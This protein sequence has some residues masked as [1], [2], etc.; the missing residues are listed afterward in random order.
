MSPA[1]GYNIALGPAADKVIYPARSAFLGH[2]VQAWYRIGVD[3]SGD[4]E[5]TWLPK[6][7]SW[8]NGLTDAF[9]PSYSASGQV[10]AAVKNTS[11]TPLLARWN[12]DGTGLATSGSVGENHLNLL[13]TWGMA[14][15][16]SPVLGATAP[17]IN[18][19]PNVGETLSATTGAWLPAGSSSFTYDWQ[20]CAPDGNSCLGVQTGAQSSYALTAADL[21]SRIRVRVTAT[22]G[23]GQSIASSAL[24]PADPGV[25]LPSLQELALEFRPHLRFDGDPGT[26]EG[27]RW[28]PVAIDAFVAEQFEP[29]GH[30][31]EFCHL[32]VVDLIQVV[33]CEPFSDLDSF[34]AHPGGQPFVGGG[35]WWA[36]FDDA[37][38]PPSSSGCSHDN[39]YGTVVVDCEGSGSKLYF[40][41]GIDP[42]GL[43]FLDY[44][45]FLRYND[46]PAPLSDHEGDWE[47]AVVALELST[48]TTVP[49]VSAVALAAH[50]DL[51]W[52]LRS[53][54][55]FS[56]DHAIAYV[57]N[58]TH[59]AFPSSCPSGCGPLERGYDGLAYWG[60]NS[61]AACG[62]ECVQP[63]PT[64]GWT[65]WG[66]TWGPDTGPGGAGNS[67]A[68]P[69]NQDRYI[70]TSIGFT[71]S[72]CPFP[73]ASRI[74]AGSGRTRGLSTIRNCDGW[75]G[76]GVALVA[77]DPM[78]LSKSIR[79][80]RLDAPGQ[81]EIVL[82]S[83]RSGSFPGLAQVVGRPLRPDESFALV[84]KARPST[85]VSV[86][87]EVEGREF[88][89]SFKIGDVP[90]S[91]SSFTLTD[92]G[93]TP[94]LVAKGEEVPIQRTTRTA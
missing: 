28:R 43:L 1:S 5:L 39:G 94:K 18:G 35:T 33:E 71:D 47:G 26:G 36:D 60:N 65:F 68:S 42:S 87:A 77:C 12:T 29:D 69:G 15:D 54:L 64:S 19:Y 67:P 31:H 92:S 21:G 14:S 62:T 61:D 2:T 91:A 7:G 84:G 48:G 70:C 75:M 32:V 73:P 11:S 24:Y 74:G 85:V 58:G 59:A 82:R 41:P 46:S 10:M 34:D 8:V 86:A 37:K 76:P 51:T 30:R 3:G 93:R 16:G 23:V 81:L 38:A 53:E 66:G 63:F 4:T 9:A 49:A 79:L 78:L 89:L 44:W 20:R 55:S 40:H 72:S 56:G 80:R 27:E 52:M 22:N 83:H 25:I 88:V 57:G 50:D 45:W 17:A 6:S 13:P 90:S